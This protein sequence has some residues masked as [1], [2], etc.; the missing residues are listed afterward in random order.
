ME[1]VLTYRRWLGLCVEESTLNSSFQAPF[2]VDQRS[3]LHV[4]LSSAATCIISVEHWHDRACCVRRVRALRLPTCPSVSPV[5]TATSTGT[6]D[7]VTLDVPDFEVASRRY[8]TL[9][10]R[11]HRTFACAT[12]TARAH[13]VEL[14]LRSLPFHGWAGSGVAVLR[15]PGDTTVLPGSP[16][17]TATA[18]L[19]L[20][21][22]TPDTPP[23]GGRILRRA[24]GH[25][26]PWCH[27][28][29]RDSFQGFTVCKTWL[30]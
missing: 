22:V 16:C 5:S 10:A 11:A 25:R 15:T 19:G 1:R 4:F 13:S 29:T 7:T 12:C 17:D 3:L 30:G 2:T 6:V 8:W 24:G 14:P 28:G 27:H 18:P 9:A 21:P 20:C 26:V 23:H